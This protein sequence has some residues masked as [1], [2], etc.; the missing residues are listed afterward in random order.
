MLTHKMH[1]DTCTYNATAVVLRNTLPFSLPYKTTK[2]NFCMRY[3]PR[4]PWR[5]E[6]L[7]QNGFQLEASSQLA[8][9]VGELFSIRFI[10]FLKAYSCHMIYHEGTTTIWIENGGKNYT[11]QFITP[12]KNT[13]ITYYRKKLLHRK[14]VSRAI[15]KLGLL[16]Q[17]T[18]KNIILSAEF[19]LSIR[20]TV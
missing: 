8:D 1:E 6:M 2:A 11:A 9:V 5:Y 20:M 3:Q 4:S 15:R 16:P 13:L 14:T 18:D 17:T 12:V 10:F 7:Q 19:R